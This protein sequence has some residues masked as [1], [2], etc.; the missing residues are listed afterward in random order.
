MVLTAQMLESELMARCLAGKAFTMVKEL[1]R[2]RTQSVR[3]D[4]GW[5]ETVVARDPRIA[6]GAAE[7]VRLSVMYPELKI[8]YPQQTLSEYRPVEDDALR[9][10]LKRTNAVI[11]VPESFARQHSGWDFCALL[12]AEWSDPLA[13]LGEA[14]C[15]MLR[16]CELRTVRMFAEKDARAQIVIEVAD[17]W[18]RTKIWTVPLEKHGLYPLQWDAEHCGMALALRDLLAE[19]LSAECGESLQITPARDAQHKTASLLLTYHIQD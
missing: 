1:G 11:E 14:V 5:E 8:T 17:E 15:K 10:G 9:F 18:I 2:Y 6:E 19:A 7:V 3:T 4:D 13:S 16:K 12:K